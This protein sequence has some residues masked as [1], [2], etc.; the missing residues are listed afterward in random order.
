MLYNK[1]N[2]NILKYETKIKIKL[3]KLYSV[4]ILKKNINKYI[5]V[6]MILNYTL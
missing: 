3:R 2:I 1:V 4:F 6:Y 5:K